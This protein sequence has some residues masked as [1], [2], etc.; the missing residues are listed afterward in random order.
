MTLRGGICGCATKATPVSPKSARHTAFQ[1][2]C[3]LTGWSAQQRADI[4]R[5]RGY[6]RFDHEACLRNAD[7]HRR[8]A[9][10]CDRHAYADCEYL[11]KRRISLVLVDH[12][13]AARIDQASRSPSTPHQHRER[14][15]ASSIREGQ[16]CVSRTPP[17]S[18]TSS[19][20]MLPLVDIF[21]A[22]VGDPFYMLRAH[23][24]FE[25]TPG[26]ADPVKPEM[27]DIGFG[28][29]EGHRHAIAKLATSQLGFQNEWNS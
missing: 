22:G 23:L 26:V 11:G 29:N 4:L 18:A 2:G 28:S 6:H 25:Q 13:E 15:A 3:A 20:D 5:D 9:D 8:G 10:R 1:V 17:S 7:W 24:T 12:D 21:D 14:P 16:L 19:T 27:P